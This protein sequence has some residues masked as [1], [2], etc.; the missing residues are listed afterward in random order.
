MTTPPVR[1][2]FFAAVLATA[3]VAACQAPGKGMIALEGAT[4]IDGTGGPPVKDALI[5]I[6]GGHIE[7]VSQVNVIHVPRGAQHINLVGK[8]IIPGLFDA[9]AHAARWALP[10]FIA[11]GVTSIRDV[12]DAPN[13]SLLA[14]RS[15]LGLGNIMGP[16]MFTPGSGIDA[17]P[18]FSPAWVAA[19]SPEEARKAVD[20]RINA[21]ADYVMAEPGVPASL[22]RAIMDEAS[23]LHTPVAMTPG[24]VD[25]LSAA[26]G[27]VAVLD[28]LTGIVTS[29][30]R[31]PAPYYRAWGQLWS[32]LGNEERGW[33]TADSN[34][35]AAMA[36][37]LA[38][39]HVAVVPILAFHDALA[40]LNDT[41][42]TSGPGWADVPPSMAAVRG[43]ADLLKQTGWSARDLIAFRGA[44][45]RQ[46]QFL[47]EFRHNGGLVAAGSGAPGP[48]LVPG[49]A[50]HQEMALLVA[51]GFT[52]LEAITFATRYSAELLHADSLGVVEAGRL[53][54]LVVLNSDPSQKIDATRDI[55]W[56]MLRGAVFHPDSMRMQWAHER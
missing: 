12:G 3:L 1:S 56:V 8:T 17:A 36:K 13:D 35:V 18:A 49:E 11:W 33:A 52:P 46:N 21:N 23:A 43:T 37:N 38:I 47:R 53:A 50:L 34:A 25:A 5:L 27:G 14:L 10:R 29:M 55:A 54:D 48:G 15:D 2:S 31:N 24:R 4:L 32:G 30:A 42:L 51:A 22:L 41:S 20:A 26:H 7:A 9:H 19:A 44:R 40:R 28:G 6:R 39:T 16:R 45:K